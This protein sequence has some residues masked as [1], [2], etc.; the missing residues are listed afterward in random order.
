MA[1]EKQLHHFQCQICGYVYETEEEELPD[2][3][4][5]P[6]CGASKDNFVKLD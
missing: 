6:L 3:F 4:V 1:E 2:G 5:C